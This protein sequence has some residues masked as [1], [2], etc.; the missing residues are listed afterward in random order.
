MLALMVRAYVTVRLALADCAI[1][2]TIS[3][4]LLIARLVLLVSA[5]VL[6][7]VRNAAFT[8]LNATECVTLDTIARVADSARVILVA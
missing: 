7:I 2:D 5:L 1:L 4:V 3:R 6:E 8:R